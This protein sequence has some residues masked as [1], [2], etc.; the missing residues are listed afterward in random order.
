MPHVLVTGATGFLG[1]TLTRALRAQG[2]RVTGIGRDEQK[3][4]DL[5]HCGATVLRHDLTRPLNP[6]GLNARGGVDALVHCAALSS[7]FGPREAFVSHNV[8]AT[9]NA[10]NLA[11]SLGIR[12]FIYVSTPAVYFRFADQHHVREDA[13]LPPPLTAYADTKRRGEEIVLSWPEIG[14]VVLRPRG[15]YGK[16]DTALLPRLARAARS[17]PLPLLRNGEAQTDITHV[18]DAVAAII[19]ALRAPAGIAGHTFNVSGGAGIPIKTI[20]ET[21]CA[22][23]G[24]TPRWRTL[25]LKPLLSMARLSEASARL[26]P[27]PFEPR[28]TLYGVGLFAYSQTLDI[29]KAARMLAWRPSVSF[30]E[31]LRRTFAP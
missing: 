10:V 22:R 14:P 5:E 11:K 17:G 2:D 19:C 27:W 23:L 3:C 7:P 18:D 13:A 8:I 9:Q 4:R 16:G 25:P 30:D 1:S 12:R 24:I 29:S 21:A 31:G 28:L 15:L 26:S 20:A 6:G